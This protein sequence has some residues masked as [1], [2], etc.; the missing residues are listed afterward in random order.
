LFTIFIF[1]PC[2]PLIPLLMYPAAQNSKIDLIMV[3]CVFGAVT[4]STMLAAVLISKAGIDLIPLA[5]VQRYSHAIA[6]A[7]IFLCGLA[8]VFLGL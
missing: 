4:I 3:T 5:K 8:I 7:S 1:G 2:E 6:G